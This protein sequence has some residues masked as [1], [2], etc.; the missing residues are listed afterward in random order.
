MTM[1][2]GPTRDRAIKLLQSIKFA[3]T[4]A[5]LSALFFL[6]V[7]IGV[8][9]ITQSIL[10]Q[11][12]LAQLRVSQR[13]ELAGL[14]TLACVDVIVLWLLVG[15]WAGILLMAIVGWLIL[16]GIALSFFY[17]KNSASWIYR[18]HFGEYIIERVRM[19]TNWF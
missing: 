7:G 8:F 1:L 2:S 6:F 17:F 15:F 5:I 3:V 19:R 16:V 4:Y 11:L 13:Q 18:S 12:A 10:V 14:A 9:L